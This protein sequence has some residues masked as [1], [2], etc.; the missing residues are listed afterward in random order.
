MERVKI[1]TIIDDRTGKTRD[2]YEGDK[3]VTGD[4]L[5]GFMD[6]LKQGKV[7]DNLREQFENG[8][9]FA[10][11][12]PFVWVYFTYND[13]LNL[14]DYSLERQEITRLIYFACFIN[15]EGYLKDKKQIIT[16][17]RMK[18]MSNLSENTFYKFYNKMV[19]LGIFIEDEEK[20]K[21]KDDLFS[22][23]TLTKIIKKNNDFTRLYTET[24]K[25]L[26]ENVKSKH[27]NILGIY[28]GLIPY[29]HRQSN[30]ICYNPE[31][32]MEDIQIMTMGD[33]SKIVDY[34]KKIGQF[35]KDMLDLKLADGSKILCISNCDKDE[36]KTKMT[37]N[38]DVIYGGNYYL[39]P[40]N[41]EVI[42]AYFV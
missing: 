30:I 16:K 26:Y 22:K 38:P 17:A 4:Q 32:E 19:E 27:H 29:I 12:D 2:L 18:N 8:D 34:R 23:G 28:F 37:I 11:V 10:S 41:R 13:L 3:L 6:K 1:G 15:Y 25:Y 24:V 39:I 35:I 36:K 40:E 14:E 9:L 42:M 21:I 20:I 7:R 31:S 33:L 5:K